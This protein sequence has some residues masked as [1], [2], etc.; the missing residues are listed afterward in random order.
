MK[1]P[2]TLL[3]N[4]NC[5]EWRDWGMASPVP[6][7]I[8]KWLKTW[9]PTSRN[10]FRT[11]TTRPLVVVGFHQLKLY[12]KYETPINPQPQGTLL[13]PLTTLNHHVHPLQQAHVAQHITFDGDDVGIF[14]CGDGSHF[15]VFFHHHRWPI[16]GA[17]NGVHR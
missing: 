8:I 1:A 17:T 11:T 4:P 12:K 9:L 3:G 6:A 13:H 2:G 7:E 5:I 10:T 15:V 16:S 14:A